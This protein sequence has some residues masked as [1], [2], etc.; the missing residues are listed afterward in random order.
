MKRYQETLCLLCI[1]CLMFASFAT[2]GTYPELSYI[3]LAVAVFGCFT[4]AV[5]PLETIK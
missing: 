2:A 3:M 4:L 1:S 5:A